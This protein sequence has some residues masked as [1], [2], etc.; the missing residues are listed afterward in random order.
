ME[1]TTQQTHLNIAALIA[2]KQVY[3]YSRFTSSNLVYL[4]LGL[5]G[6]SLKGTNG[7]SQWFLSLSGSVHVGETSSLRES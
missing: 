3:Y 4:S 5:D 1:I 7:C 2:T 6:G